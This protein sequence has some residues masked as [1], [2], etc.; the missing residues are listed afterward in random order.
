[1]NRSEEVVD[2]VG[3]GG[4]SNRSRDSYDEWTVFFDNLF[5]KFSE[6]DEDD[7]FHVDM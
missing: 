5:R 2:E 1:M 6:Q 4:F 3:C 7:L